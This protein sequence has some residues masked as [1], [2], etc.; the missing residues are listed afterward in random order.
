[1]FGSRDQ[2]TGDDR[3]FFYMKFTPYINIARTA[4]VG[5]FR[6]WFEIGKKG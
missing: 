3:Y 2:I 6:I 1:M 4:T 5:T